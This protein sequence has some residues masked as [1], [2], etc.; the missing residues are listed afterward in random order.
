MQYK[1][2]A[3]LLAALGALFAVTGCVSREGTPP[4]Q[5]G[6][7]LS[8]ESP[9]ESSKEESASQPPETEPVGVFDYESMTH[10]PE[11]MQALERGENLTGFCLRRAVIDPQQV[12]ALLAAW[13]DGGD[14]ELA[15]TDFSAYD[16]TRHRLQV[17]GGILSV[18]SVTYP[19]GSGQ[20]SGRFENPDVPFMELL[21]NAVLYLRDGREGGDLALDFRG[22]DFGDERL[23]AYDRYLRDLEF[24]LLGQTWEAGLP[25][26]Y[27][28]QMA[29]YF[30][31]SYG[32]DRLWQDYPQGDFPPE[33]FEGVIQEHFPISSAQLRA[34]TGIWRE[35]SGT[36]HYEGGLGGAY[37]VTTR[38]F[39]IK[40]E[41]DRL[42]VVYGFDDFDLD[43]GYTYLAGDEG[44][45]AIQSR[46]ERYVLSVRPKEDGGF[47]YLA[48]QELAQN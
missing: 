5:G 39:E 47:E 30:E 41:A 33:V 42:L 29:Y 31:L 8:M 36:Y 25:Q 4:P 43:A 19:Y 34:G 16:Y 35:E 3:A 14:A 27:A 9:S 26:T 21:S 40:E 15:V 13:K 28:G 18:S 2:G 7:S 38:V 46:P 10:L 17:K 23:A 44:R 32:M 37:T 1:I 6:A 48:N 22:E 24:N 45:P 12:N 11:F 20:E